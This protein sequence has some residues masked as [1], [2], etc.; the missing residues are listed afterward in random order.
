MRSEYESY[1]MSLKSSQKFTEPQVRLVERPRG[2]PV[3]FYN[4]KKNN[5][6]FPSILIWASCYGLLVTMVIPKLLLASSTAFYA[7]ETGFFDE[8]VTGCV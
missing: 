6:M 7:V 2:L 5:N 3:E 4:I 1:I 8:R